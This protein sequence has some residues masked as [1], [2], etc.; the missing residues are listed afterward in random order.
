MLDFSIHDFRYVS[1]SQL[2]ADAR[3]SR[4]K[5]AVRERHKRNV[6]HVGSVMAIIVNILEPPF[7]Y[8]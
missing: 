2:S 3:I 7:F 5:S 1:L 6:E 4:T 8:K